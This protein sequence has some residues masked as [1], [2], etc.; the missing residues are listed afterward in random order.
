MTIAVPP[1]SM[2]LPL[3]AS[4]SQQAVRIRT[5]LLDRLVAE[6]GEVIITR[7]RLEAELGQLRGSLSDLTGN[8][9]R[10]RQRKR[11]LLVQRYP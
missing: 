9:D 11:H 3:R 1:S 7:S 5:Q 2:L 8:L 6:A 10:L 4:S